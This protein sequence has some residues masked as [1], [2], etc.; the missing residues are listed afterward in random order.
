MKPEDGARKQIEIYRK[1]TGKQ[2]LRIAMEL[3]ELSRELISANIRN[4]HPGISEE[5]F[6]KKLAER[7]SKW[8]K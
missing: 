2:R 4:S 3:Y 6:R 7:M 1:M 8:R 5:E